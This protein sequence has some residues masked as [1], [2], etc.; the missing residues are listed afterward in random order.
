[1][2]NQGKEDLGILVAEDPQYGQLR[3]Q[4]IMAVQ[5]KAM[6]PVVVVVLVE[7]RQALE[8]AEAAHQALFLLL[9]LVN[10]NEK[11]KKIIYK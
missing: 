3:L 1:V 6:A 10:N 9:N 8:L 11:S 2:V 7:E 5:D 4:V